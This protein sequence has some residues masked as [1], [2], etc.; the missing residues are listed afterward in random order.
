MARGRNYTFDWKS[1]SK[2][3]DN[4]SF[5]SHRK[6]SSSLNL[7]GKYKPGGCQDYYRPGDASESPRDEDKDW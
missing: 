5:D 4:E 2:L 6:P 1:L 7:K 3:L